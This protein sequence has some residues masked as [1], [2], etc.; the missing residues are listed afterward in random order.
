MRFDFTTVLSERDATKFLPA[1]G[2]IFEMGD[3]GE[4]LYVVKSGQAQIRVGD[5][6]LET[7]EKGD[8]LGEMAVLDE[9]IQQRSASAFAVT[10]CEVVGMDRLR[11]IELL[12][13]NPVVGLEVSK[14]MVRR[15]RLTTFLSHHDRLTELPNQSFPNQV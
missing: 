5:I 6:V 2:S 10:D 13:S 4:L 12:R 8:L 11:V 3:L 7:L 15:L 14:L 1:G 9:Q